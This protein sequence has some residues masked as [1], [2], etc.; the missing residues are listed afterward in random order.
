M[1]A[2]GCVSGP[3]R[4]CDDPLGGLTTLPDP[5]ALSPTAIALRPVAHAGELWDYA[6][7]VRTL[8][9]RQAMRV[10]ARDAGAT[11][12]DVLIDVVEAYVRK[13]IARAVAG[14]HLPPPGGAGA[15]TP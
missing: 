3:G 11:G 9:P 1:P 13:R 8:P 10:V 7:Y 4:C 5:A 12:A 6:Q 15:R 2:R 14:R